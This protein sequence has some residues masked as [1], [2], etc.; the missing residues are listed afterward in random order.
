MIYTL[1]SSL[2]VYFVQF[3]SEMHMLVVTVFYCWMHLF[4]YVMH[5]VASYIAIIKYTAD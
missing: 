1:C 5:G 3:G 2:R 4:M